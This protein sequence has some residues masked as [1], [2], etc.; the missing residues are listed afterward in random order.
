MDAKTIGALASVCSSRDWRDNSL[1]NS[2]I[3][4]VS[5]IKHRAIAAITSQSTM[6]TSYRVK[7]RKVNRTHAIRLFTFVLLVA[8]VVVLGCEGSI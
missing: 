3:T 8:V 2:T 7:G 4:R 6:P 5:A 1:A